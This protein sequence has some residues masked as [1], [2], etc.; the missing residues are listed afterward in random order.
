[1]NIFIFLLFLFLIFSL[2]HLSLLLINFLTKKFL[3]SL[4]Q[5]KVYFD[6]KYNIKIKRL[7]KFL[8][9]KHYLMLYNLKSNQTHF[10]LIEI[11]VFKIEYIIRMF[12]KTCL[13]L[14]AFLCKEKRKHGNYE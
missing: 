1:M 4:K 8:H 6:E 13:L 14:L 3:K 11:I 7:T 2:Y 9:F 10:Y 12:L 5:L